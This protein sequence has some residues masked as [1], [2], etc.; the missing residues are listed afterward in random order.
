MC[1]ILVYKLFL[2]L[3]HSLSVSRKIYVKK[4]EVRVSYFK[5]SPVIV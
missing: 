3:F 1:K 5:A 4:I 2:I